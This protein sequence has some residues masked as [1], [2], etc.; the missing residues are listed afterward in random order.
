ME[1]MRQGQSMLQSPSDRK[2]EIPPGLHDFIS[3]EFEPANDS[4][5]I[6]HRNK[7]SQRSQA[8][9]NDSKMDI[10]DQSMA[11]VNAGDQGTPSYKTEDAP[12]KVI[13]ACPNVWTKKQTGIVHNNNNN[14]MASDMEAFYLHS[15]LNK[16]QNASEKSSMQLNTM[17]KK[18]FK[19]IRIDKKMN[20]YCHANMIKND[21]KSI[22]IDQ[23]IQT[24]PHSIS[25]DEKSKKEIAEALNLNKNKPARKRHNSAL[26]DSS[27]P[28]EVDSKVEQYVL[29]KPPNASDELRNYV[30]YSF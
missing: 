30:K 13:R 20:E 5:M 8:A 21:F 10:N 9:D 15:S 16:D 17:L 29:M 28:N 11:T 27:A 6:D 19:D 23:F 4:M 14:P 22:N 12:F 24:F 26:F 2:G 18:I 3:S 25:N 7:Q 1:Q